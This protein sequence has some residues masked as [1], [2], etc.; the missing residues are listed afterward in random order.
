[1]RTLIVLVVA[2]IAACLDQPPRPGPGPGVD[3]F[4]PPPD[5]GSGSGFD[6]FVAEPEHSGDDGLRLDGIPACARDALDHA[7]SD[8]LVD[9][10]R[11]AAV[12][13]DDHE[14][15]DHR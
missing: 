1:M 5:L 10:H 13:G 7:K 6:A 9:A 2:A 11:R 15:L 14:L 4:V 8:A 12:L 3:A